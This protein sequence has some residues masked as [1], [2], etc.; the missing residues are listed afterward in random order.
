MFFHQSLSLWQ[1]NGLAPES[2]VEYSLSGSNQG[3]GCMDV[4]KKM[5]APAQ[6]EAQVRV[7]KE[8]ITEKCRFSSKQNR[9]SYAITSRDGETGQEVLFFGK[10]G[11]SRG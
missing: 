10:R 4:W 11:F 5:S 8:I 1:E 3:G 9:K 2:L 6:R 7:A